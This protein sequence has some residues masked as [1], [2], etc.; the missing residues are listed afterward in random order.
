MPSTLY[1]SLAN[2]EFISSPQPSLLQVKNMLISFLA[3]LPFTLH[4]DFPL[5]TTEMVLAEVTSDL[6]FAQS[7]GCLL[8]PSGWLLT[9]EAS[10]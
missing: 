1:A 10:L 3:F 7:G 6:P 8:V 2:T 4:C 9:F 5:N